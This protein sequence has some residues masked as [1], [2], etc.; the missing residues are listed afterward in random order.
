MIDR[1]GSSGSYAQFIGISVGVWQGPS[2]ICVTNL[3]SK[4][5]FGRTNGVFFWS[6]KMPSFVMTLLCYLKTSFKNYSFDPKSLISTL[7]CSANYMDKIM[8]AECGK[9]LLTHYHAPLLNTW[10]ACYFTG[11]III[12]RVSDCGFPQVWASQQYIL[13]WWWATADMALSPTTW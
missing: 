10:F 8:L 4:V 7:C 9:T 2:A 1:R 13:V 6:F 11:A 5:K 12:V 3:F